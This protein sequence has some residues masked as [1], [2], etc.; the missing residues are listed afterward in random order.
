MSLTQETTPQTIEQELQQLIDQAHSACSVSGAVSTQ[1]AAA[2]DAVEEVQAAISHR[3]DRQVNS[4][5]V[6]CGEHPDAPECR[7]YD[8]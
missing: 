2:W 1:C 7:I 3:R 6:H 5:D 8:I 4:L